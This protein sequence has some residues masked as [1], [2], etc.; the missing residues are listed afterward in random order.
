MLIERMRDRSLQTRLLSD[1]HIQYKFEATRLNWYH[2]ELEKAGDMP[3]NRDFYPSVLYNDLL[4]WNSIHSPGFFKMFSQLK[5]V[6]LSYI[7]PTIICVFVPFFFLQ[8]RWKRSCIVLP[9]IT[10]GFSGMGVDIVLVLAFQSFYGY[11]YHWIG[12]LIAAFMVGL[13]CGGMWMTRRLQRKI[14]D[15]SVFLKLEIFIVLYTVLLIGI[16]TILNRFQEYTFVF[17]AVQYVLLLLNALCGFLVGAEFPLANHIYLKTTAQY[18]QTAGILYASDLIGSWIG[19]LFVTIACIPLFGM[20]N[21][22][23]LIVIVNVCSVGLFY[24]S[25]KN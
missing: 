23:V 17:S 14:E 9:I 22:C 12:L 11:L 3:L 24:V 20:M 7:I 6:R 8:R 1:F 2:N 4:F 19:A 10:T 25:R 5:R 16:L 13:T 21:T 15:Y 18:T